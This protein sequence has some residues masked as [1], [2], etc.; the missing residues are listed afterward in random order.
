V[1]VGVDVCSV[2]EIV[3]LVVCVKEDAVV[4]DV[5]VEVAVLDV[6]LSS[7]PS[8]LPKFSSL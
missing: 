1:R 3:L 8:P 6:D 7:A 2:G 5:V 4:L